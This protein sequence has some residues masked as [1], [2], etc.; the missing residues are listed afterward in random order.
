MIDENG[1]RQ[2]WESIG[3]KLG[4]RERRLWAAAEVE[5]AGYGGLAVVSRITGIARSTINRGEDDLDAAPLPRGQ[6]RRS[7][8]G[9]RGDLQ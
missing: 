8:G 9:R 6:V 2:R 4:E 3:S 7:G 1:I 5:A